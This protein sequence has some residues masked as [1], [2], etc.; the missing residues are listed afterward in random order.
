MADR[1]LDVRQ[2]SDSDITS[3]LGRADR[4]R[5]NLHIGGG[6]R[7]LGIVRGNVEA[8]AGS[9]VLI[10]GEGGRVEGDVRV[11]RARVDGAVEGA[12]DIAGHLDVSAGAVINGD[13]TYGSMTVVAGATIN[14]H[15][16]CRHSEF[17]ER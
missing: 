4:T 1:P 3:V 2:A 8:S 6:L 17:N 14:G 7:V 12:L 16:R 15:V 9:A 13:I 11:D 5:G 10:V